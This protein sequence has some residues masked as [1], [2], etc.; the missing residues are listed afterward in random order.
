MS[1]VTEQEFLAREC[2]G[3]DQFSSN[4]VVEAKFTSPP[5]GTFNA[6]DTRSD[7]VFGGA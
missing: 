4:G 7:I 1:I 3:F 5:Q 2:L 6:L